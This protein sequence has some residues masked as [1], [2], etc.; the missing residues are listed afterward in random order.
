MGSVDTESFLPYITRDDDV[1]FAELDPDSSTDMMRQQ[2]SPNFPFTF[3]SSLPKSEDFGNT[4]L[5]TNGTKLSPGSS[6]QDSISNSSNERETFGDNIQSGNKR[7]HEFDGGAWY[8]PS[9]NQ[10]AT[11]TPN[12]P[13]LDDSN[14]VME[15]DFDFDSAASSPGANILDTGH[16]NR[17]VA[18]PAEQSPL[19][20]M[21][22]PVED[23][24]NSDISLAHIIDSY[25]SRVHEQPRQCLISLF[26]IINTI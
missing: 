19:S 15:R 1:L 4:N 10:F 21:S 26:V 24:S 8:S 23:V 13:N 3:A 2:N 6:L 22:P 7:S 16:V 12:F 14:Q 9:Q 11:M 25:S 17:H 18:I 5:A 20:V